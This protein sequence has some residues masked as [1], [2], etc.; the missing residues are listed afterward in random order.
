[1]AAMGNKGYSTLPRTLLESIIFLS[2][3]LPIRTV[4]MFIELRIGADTASQYATQP[5]AIALDR[6]VYQVRDVFGKLPN[7][8]Q[9]IRG[10]V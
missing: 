8:A 1:M 9:L 6:C 5:E 4:E 3:A 7:T 10:I 2:R